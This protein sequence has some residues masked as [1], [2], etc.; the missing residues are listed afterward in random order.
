M[1]QHESTQTPP[2]ASLPPIPAAPPSTPPPAAQPWWESATAGLPPRPQQ[3]PRIPIPGTA[4]WSTRAS[5]TLIEISIAVGAMGAYQLALMAFTPVFAFVEM[6]AYAVGL[7]G[8]SLF[9]TLDTII[10][11]AFFLWQWSL[12]GTTGQ[13]LGQKLMGIAVVDE[14][15]GQPLGASR[16]ILRSV[17]HIADIGTVFFGYI[18]PVF[19]YRR[20][21][22]ADSISRS[23]VIYMPTEKTL[24]AQ[25]TP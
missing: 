14:D 13:S 16:S 7:D 20:Q 3:R 6:I 23:V 19:Q 21:T 8:K 11:G 15:T 22:F 24:P 25:R 18:R 2:A 17:L 4:D 5:A 12:R 10:M 9:G 1:T